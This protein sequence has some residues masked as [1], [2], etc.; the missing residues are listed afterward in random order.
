MHCWQVTPAGNLTWYLKSLFPCPISIL[1]PPA[2]NSRRCLLECFANNVEV[3]KEL[4]VCL[5]IFLWPVKAFLC[6][7]FRWVIVFAQ[8]E[9]EPAFV[10][11]C[12]FH[13]NIYCLA[14]SVIG[15]N[16]TRSIFSGGL[17]FFLAIP[18]QFV[19]YALSNYKRSAW[20]Y[21]NWYW[22]GITTN[23]TFATV[24]I[25]LSLQN[26]NYSW[27]IHISSFKTY[28]KTTTVFFIVSDV[29]WGVESYSPS[30]ATSWRINQVTMSSHMRQLKPDIKYF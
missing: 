22:P 29:P 12:Y 1:V 27:R 21:K 2:V 28:C 23:S 11:C 18:E 15:N 9:L 20:S 25:P 8:F 13:L 16:C 7:V 6:F 24:D 3:H 10:V 19:K 17:I 14:L 26:H 4:F 5:C 30:W